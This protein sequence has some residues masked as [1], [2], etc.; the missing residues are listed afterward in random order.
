MWPVA[1][2]LKELTAADEARI[3][4]LVKES[5]ELRRSQHFYAR[6]EPRRSTD[7]VPGD[8]LWCDRSRDRAHVLTYD[9]LAMTSRHLS[10][11]FG[12]AALLLA[13]TCTALPTVVAQHT[14]LPTAAPATV[15]FSPE[16]LLTLDASM[17][18]FVDDGALSGVVT[19]VAR[20]GKIV[21]SNVYGYQDIAQKVP[22][23]QDTIFRI[24][25]MTKPI[26]G[27]AMMK[28]Y[29]QGKWHPDDPLSRYIPEFANLQVYAG[30]DAAGKT[31]LEKPAHAPT[32][33]ELM[34]HT[35][36]FTYGF[37]GDTVVDKQYQADSPFA[38]PTLQGFVEKLSRIPLLYQPGTQW[39]YSVSVDV[40]GYLV[41]KLSGKSLP[42][43]MRQEIFEPLGMRDT[44][45][46]VPTSKLERLATVYRF[47][48]KAGL[49]PAVRD[50]NISTV[51]GLAS[52]GGGL[53]STARDY[54][55]FAQMLANGGRLNGARIL[56]PS[57]V[58]L[59][60]AN[61]LPD[62]LRDNRFGIGIQR[63]RP[64]FGFGYD[65]AVFDDPHKAG[66]TTGTGT[67]LW[68]GAAGTWFW[69]DPT[70]DIVFVGMVQRMIGPGMPD[71]ENLSRALVQQ[72]LLEP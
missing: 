32:V 65:V 5:G 6:G 7:R 72:A 15:G 43:Y 29:E 33:G 51:P 48:Q 14:E 47:D 71:L 24:Y 36:G 61:H 4:A 18:K 37:F 50:P 44:S 67:F 9:V 28:L 59:M 70:N 62:S 10:I 54:S 58:S 2:T 1:F 11:R 39:V 69:I 27:V 66:S 40:Q 55:R 35:A 19:L 31:K 26:T 41:E 46:A 60:R 20:H 22:M 30:T 21:S 13:L 12:P 3:G 52:G 38:A 42:D 68:D 53:Y 45:F 49:T 64:G 8:S 57:S 56:A 25:S 63:M 23:R 34:T 17:K 16:R